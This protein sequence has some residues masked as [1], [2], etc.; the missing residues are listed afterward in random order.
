MLPTTPAI[1]DPDLC[2]RG[3]AATAV[4]TQR[5]GDYA[6]DPLETPGIVQRMI[7]RGSRILDVGCGN[8]RL[9][10]ILRDDGGCT[11]LG[12]EPSAERAGVARERGLEVIV[13]LFTEELARSI[14]TVDFVVFADVLE[15]LADPTALLLLARSVLKPGGS[16]IISVPN[17]VH[18]TIRGDVF[19]GRFNYSETGLMDATHLRWFT[20]ESLDRLLTDAGFTVSQRSVS[21]GTWMKIYTRIPFSLCS[22][23]VLR[24]ALSHFK[25]WFPR[26]FGCQLVFKATLLANTADPRSAKQAVAHA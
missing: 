17:A 15:H 2:S 6:N 18:W 4:R 25:K 16:V 5:Y 13:G 12:I 8:G 26:I 7:P 20:W 9:G 10:E 19:R 14:E 23:R 22:E 24:I 11:V 21:A 3:F 1:T